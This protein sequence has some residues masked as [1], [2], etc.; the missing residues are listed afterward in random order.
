MPGVEPGQ[1]AWETH[2]GMIL[3]HAVHHAL[4]LMLRPGPKVQRALGVSAD[5]PAGRQAR[6]AR[7][8]AD[9]IRPC[10]DALGGR[11]DGC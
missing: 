10:P 3:F 4:A 11:P 9:S 7:P 6:P 2:R 1:A 5:R 8:G